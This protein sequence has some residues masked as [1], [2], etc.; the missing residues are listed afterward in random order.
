MEQVNT[1]A[2]EG[3]V[4]ISH[5]HGTLVITSFLSLDQ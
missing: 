5:D 2:G 4:S 1:G 3:S